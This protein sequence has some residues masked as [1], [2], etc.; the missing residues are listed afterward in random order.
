MASIKDWLAQNGID[1]W[2][3][4]LDSPVTI[5][6]AGDNEHFVSLHLVK[7][8]SADQCET[9]VQAVHEDAAGPINITYSQAD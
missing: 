3:I 4:P 1:G 6:G 9:L 5:N 2:F 7:A 8:V